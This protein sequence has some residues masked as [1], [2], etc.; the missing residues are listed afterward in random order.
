MSQELHTIITL[1]EASHAL[2]IDRRYV[3]EIVEAGIVE[4]ELDPSG[5]APDDWQFDPDM[6]ARM[7]RACRLC[8]DLELDWSSAALVLDLLADRE[9]L[10]RENQ[11]LR[12][13][14][15]RFMDR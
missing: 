12:R 11:R 7:Q 4:P 1:T 14:L 15:E 9:R 3:V 8:R 10:Q 5:T 13:L 2:G 6:M